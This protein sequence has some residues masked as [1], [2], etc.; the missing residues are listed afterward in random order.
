MLK[1]DPTEPLQYGNPKKRETLKK[2]NEVK[3]KV[4]TEKNVYLAF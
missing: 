2:N 4:L 1:Y 3:V